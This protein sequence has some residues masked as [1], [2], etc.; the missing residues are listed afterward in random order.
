MKQIVTLLLIALS[1]GSIFAQSYQVDLDATILKKY[2]S[3]QKGEQI[4]ITSIIHKTEID[5]NSIT[6]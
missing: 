3:F 1:I 6:T 4:K 2:E 5:E